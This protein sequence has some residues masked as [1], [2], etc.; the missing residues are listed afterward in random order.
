MY[1]LTIYQYFFKNTIFFFE[2]QEDIE[3]IELQLPLLKEVLNMF[4]INSNNIII[5]NKGLQQKGRVV[6]K[7]KKKEQS[8]ISK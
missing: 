4:G 8:I 7:V 2:H 3:I 1:K 6:Q 5:K